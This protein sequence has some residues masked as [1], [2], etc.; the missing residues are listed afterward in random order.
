MNDWIGFTVYGK[1][2]GQG[3]PRA[4]SKGGFASVYKAKDDRLYEGFIRDV[5]IQKYPALAPFPVDMPLV[6]D[7]T[8][9]LAIPASYSKNKRLM[10]SGGRLQAT[11]KPDFDNI[12]KSVADALGNGVAYVDDKQ[13]V[14]GRI[15]KCYGDV[16]KLDIRLYE[17]K[18]RLGLSS[19]EIL[20]VT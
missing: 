1:V 18:P 17:Y 20:E 7:V 6:L 15:A 12:L 4:V 9:Y 5:Y 16:D 11:K 8:A 10:A 3:R 13:I 19:T 2:R 14:R